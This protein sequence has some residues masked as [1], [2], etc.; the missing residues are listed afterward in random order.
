MNPAFL[1]SLVDP[2]G[3]SLPLKFF[4]PLSVPFF[5]LVVN[6]HEHTSCTPRPGCRL[7]RGQG[8]TLSFFSIPKTELDR[9]AAK[10]KPWL[11]NRLFFSESAFLHHLAGTRRKRWVVIVGERGQ[12]YKHNTK[13]TQ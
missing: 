12:R 4:I 3:P 2:E 11:G 6:F 10:H 5:V 7:F 1:P 8:V 9:V 13:S